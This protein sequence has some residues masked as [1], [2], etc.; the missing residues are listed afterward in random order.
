MTL[1][2]LLPPERFA[3]LRVTTLAAAV[4]ERI[5]A[6]NDVVARGAI[7]DVRRAWSRHAVGGIAAPAAE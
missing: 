2:D 6:W 4:V 3:A 5:A 1:E 7:E